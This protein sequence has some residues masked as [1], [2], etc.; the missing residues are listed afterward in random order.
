M[1]VPHEGA[2]TPGFPNA[3]W[4]GGGTTVRPG[5]VWSHLV[6]T[7]AGLSTAAGH[8]G[9]L[10]PKEGGCEPPEEEMGVRGSCDEF[11]PAHIQGA[12][13]RERVISVGLGECATGIVSSAAIASRDLSQLDTFQ[14]GSISSLHAV[15][16]CA[17]G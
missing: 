13:S 11:L 12:G 2:A 9:L 7:F 17:S 5:L 6:G 1:R 3:G 15:L 4:G 14:N 10:W 8:F 16:C